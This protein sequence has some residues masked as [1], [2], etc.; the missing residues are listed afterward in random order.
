MKQVSC[1][2]LVVGGGVAG[3]CA[4][5]AAARRGVQTLLI[6]RQGYLGGV[7]YAGML[8]H[9]CGL[10]LNGDRTPIETLNGGLTQEIVE[11]LKKKKV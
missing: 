2:L 1:E 7:G 10:Y 5:V 8:Q 9:I 3:C 4:A 11:L 6:E